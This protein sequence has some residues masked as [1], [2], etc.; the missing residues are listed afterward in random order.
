MSI[1]DKIDEIENPIKVNKDILM[2]NGY[3]ESLW[4]A[5]DVWYDS[6]RI[7]HVSRPDC[8]IC[9][10]K[11]IVGRFKEKYRNVL[12]DVSVEIIYFP[13]IFEGYVTS[14]DGRGVKSANRIFI[15][16]NSDVLDNELADIKGLLIEDISDLR[17]A[18]MLIR[19]KLR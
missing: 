8:K 12:I 16:S 2:K 15:M 1:F 9:Y 5:P 14:L 18:E 13:E 6:N 4:G 17:M 10:T 11:I 7:K 19:K 3:Q